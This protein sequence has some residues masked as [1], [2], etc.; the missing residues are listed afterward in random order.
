MPSRSR[1]G[2]HHSSNLILLDLH[3]PDVSGRQVLSQIQ[4]DERTC[5]IPVVV[6]SADATKT[7]VDGLI[8]DGAFA[9]VTKR[10]DL[11]QFFRVI[12]QAM[13]GVQEKSPTS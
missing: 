7:Q 13:S 4:A 1:S 2:P 3:L 9:Y 5:D 6:I 8:A 10:L 12:E 11:T